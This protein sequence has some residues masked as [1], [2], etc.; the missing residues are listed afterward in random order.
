MA[1]Y[2]EEAAFKWIS[3]FFFG[4][5]KVAAV[6]KSFQGSFLRERKTA[7]MRMGSFFFVGFFFVKVKFSVQDD[8][9][10]FQKREQACLM[11]GITLAI[12]VR[13]HL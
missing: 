2:N 3:L 11:V 9:V 12:Y 5:I 4:L 13:A 10:D 1:N 6:L 8:G 7:A